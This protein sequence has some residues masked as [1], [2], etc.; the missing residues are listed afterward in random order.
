[1]GPNLIQNAIQA[2]KGDGKIEISV[3]PSGDRVVVQ[4]EDNGP[5]IPQ[6]IQDRIWDPF[7]TT[8]DQGEGTGLGLGIVKGIVEKHK[9][10]ISLTSVPGKTIFRVELPLNPELVS[11]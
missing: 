10:K 1:V 11:I 3:F 7:F 9:G 4:I 8:K 6:K 2:L 5:G